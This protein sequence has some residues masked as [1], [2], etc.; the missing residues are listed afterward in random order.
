MARLGIHQLGLASPEFLPLLKFALRA[1]TMADSC[2]L[3]LLDWTRPWKFLETLQRWI[4]VLGQ[5][6]AEICKEGT[7]T[8]GETTS[9][10][11]GKAVVDELREKCKSI[12]CKQKHR[13][14]Y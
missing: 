10:S 3:I 12:S 11:K 8:T 4:N 1:E 6:V 2:V 9:W 13:C 14:L 7:T 5:V